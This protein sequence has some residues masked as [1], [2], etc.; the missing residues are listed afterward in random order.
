M[1]GNPTVEDIR[2][3]DAHYNA[4]LNLKQQKAKAPEAVEKPKPVTPPKVQQAGQ[5]V[6]E[7]P[8]AFDKKAWVAA[9]EDGKIAMLKKLRENGRV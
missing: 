6:A 5:G 8:V 9:D 2:I 3:I 1:E 4:A 7:K